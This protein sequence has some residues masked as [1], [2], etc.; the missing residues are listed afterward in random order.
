MY[1]ILIEF[2]IQLPPRAGV[3]VNR[4]DLVVVDVGMA[5]NDIGNRVILKNNVL[6]QLKSIGL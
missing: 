3:W 2:R 5:Y 4:Y 6:N 1:G